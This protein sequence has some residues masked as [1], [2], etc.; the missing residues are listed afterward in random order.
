MVSGDSVESWLRPLGALTVDMGGVPTIPNAFMISDPRPAVWVL[1][2]RVTAVPLASMEITVP[3][4]MMA[5]PGARVCPS[6]MYFEAALAVC[7]E[8]P[9][10]ILGALARGVENNDVREPCIMPA[11]DGIRLKGPPEMV[12]R[13]PGKSVWPFIVY[14]SVESAVSCCDSIMRTGR[15]GPYSFDMLLEVIVRAVPEGTEETSVPDTVI[16]ASPVT[17]VWLP[18]RKCEEESAVTTE[19]SIVEVKI[20]EMVGGMIEEMIGET[21]LGLGTTENVKPFT[22]VETG[23]DGLDSDGICIALLSTWREPEEYPTTFVP[24]MIGEPPGVMLLPL[25]YTT[26]AT[27]LVSGALAPSWA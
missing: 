27:G 6:T 8:K 5:E 3:D 24:S 18:M 17:R 4:I 1:V 11:A 25:T 22:T 21:G 7:A 26:C 15:L 13:P 23:D 16:G 12:I 10:V 19:F 20:G 14:C 2:P 9:M